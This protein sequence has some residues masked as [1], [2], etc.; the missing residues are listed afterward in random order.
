MTQRGGRAEDQAAIATAP[1]L[2][3]AQFG[4]SNDR[5][6]TSPANNPTERTLIDTVAH[7][8]GWGINPSP[9]PAGSLFAYTVLPP[10]SPGRRGAP[11]ELWS[12]DLANGNR[13]RIARD[14]DLLIAPVLSRD[15]AELVYRVTDGEGQ[16][17]VVVDLATQLRTVL[18]RERTD[19]GLYPIGFDAEQAV[20]YA[21]LSLTG[22][23]VY[24]LPRDAEP[25]LLFHASDNI[26][27][28]WQISPDG[29]SLSFLA[30]AATAD[31][32]VYRAQA[33]QLDGAT[34]RPLATTAPLATEQYGPVW[35]PA[36]DALTIGQES[37]PDNG[38][39]AAVI[40]PD[41]SVRLLPAPGSGFDV[42]LGWSADGGYLAV[43]SFDGPNSAAPG[44]A[45]IVVIGLA[46][47]QRLHLPADSELIFIG[48]MGRA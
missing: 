28:D 14:A 4:P 48:W 3:F 23:D 31:R 9:Q 35:L 12:F 15:G 32:V 41:G 5:I 43:R 44:N 13:T 29:R 7:A 40:G 21:S 37:G 34:A 38:Q 8:D 10:D 33:V 27:R 45:Q 20:I 18:I 25:V 17:L 47:G 24:R 1:L 6:Y 11:A 2:A 26:A 19:F 42:P 30:P 36:G 46:D 39:A 22:T 16:A